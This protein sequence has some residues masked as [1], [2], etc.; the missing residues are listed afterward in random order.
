MKLLDSDFLIE[1]LKANPETAEVLRKFKEQFE[2]VTTT[3]FNGEEILFIPIYE[4]LAEEFEKGIHLL[5]T[6]KILD[7]DFD[8]MLRTLRVRSA[9][10]AHGKEIGDI[11][12]KIAGI[13][14]K[15]DA[16]LVTRN[17]EHF[18]RIPNLKVKKW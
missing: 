7:Y 10:R 14:L 16:T 8:S 17:L 6:L 11:D 4:N 2:D 9:L 1:Y 5:K 13:C 3:V 18:S 12:E 15:N